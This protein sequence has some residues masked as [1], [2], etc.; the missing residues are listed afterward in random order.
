MK[1]AA[2]TTNWSVMMDGYCRGHIAVIGHD[3]EGAG[4]HRQETVHDKHLKEA[5]R[6]A[7]GFVVKPEDGQDLR[8]DSEAEHNVQQREKAEQVVHGLMQRGLHPDG[9]EK[10]GIGPHGQEEEEAEGQGQ[11]MLPGLVVR[12]ANEEEFRDRSFRVV[13]G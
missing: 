12:K 11:A 13:A 9:D 8:D 1:M 7:Y 10:G 4:L 5:S 6:E 2:L 3:H